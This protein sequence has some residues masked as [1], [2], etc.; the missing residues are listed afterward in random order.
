M[1]PWQQ[2]QAI[3]ISQPKWA[4]LCQLGTGHEVIG[5]ELGKETRELNSN[6]ALL[7]SF[8]PSEQVTKSHLA[9]VF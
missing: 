1:P 8:G 6:S 5:R 3:S 2:L 7:T 9:S 4:L